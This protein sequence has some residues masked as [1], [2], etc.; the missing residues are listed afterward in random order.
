MSRFK[1]M[2]AKQKL[3]YWGVIGY[4][5]FIL[6]APYYVLR[7]ILAAKYRAGLKQRLTF[8]SPDLS[9]RLANGSFLWFHTVSV[10]ELQAARPL[11]QRIREAYPDKQILV[12]TI[13]E[14]GQSLAHQIDEVD[15]A[16]YLPIDLYPL[17]KRSLEMVQPK[18]VIILETELWPN[19]IR[20][21]SDQSVPLVLINGRLSDKSFKRYKLYL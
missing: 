14:T 16:I 4:V 10:G 7:M 2:S 3:W 8:Y 15:E 12:S 5:A 20:A 17:C 1:G 18:L 21:A 19:F 11:I 13:T 9:Q 6:A